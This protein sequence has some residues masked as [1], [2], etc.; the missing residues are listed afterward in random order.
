MSAIAALTARRFFSFRALAPLGWLCATVVLAWVARENG[1]A[2]V[3]LRGSFAPLILPLLVFSLVELALG[4]STL[5]THASLS[6]AFGGSP[7]KPIAS[8]ICTVASIAALH[9]GT[10]GL[11]GALVARGDSISVALTTF[12]CALAGASYAVWFLYGATMGKRGGGRHIVLGLDFIIGSGAGAGAFVFPRAHLRACL[13]GHG[14][15]GVHGAGAIG[16][17]V[18]IALSLSGLTLMR[19]RTWRS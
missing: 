6:T 15:L 7:A 13:G 14:A 3:F 9:S 11:V 16:M 2:P 1:G 12:A 8:V 5:K 18:A 19:A 10:L 17:L 4:P